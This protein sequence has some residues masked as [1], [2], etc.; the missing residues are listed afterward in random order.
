MGRQVTIGNQNKK[1]EKQASP[2]IL[3]QMLTGSFDS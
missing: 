1:R 3:R 2:Y